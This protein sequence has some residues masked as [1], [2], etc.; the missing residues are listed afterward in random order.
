MDGRRFELGSLDCL[1]VGQGSRTVVMESQ[2]AEK[3]AR[4]YLVS[5]P[6]HASHP[7]TLMR[8]DQANR[9]ELGSAAGANQRTIF[10][11]IHEGGIQS[12]QLVLGFTRLAS[13][14]VWNTMPP[15][16]HFRRSEVYLYFDLPVDQAV[17]HLAGPP[18]ETRHLVM[19]SGQAVLSP[20]WSIH[21]GCGTSSYAFVWSMG[22]ENKRFNDMD[23]API[24]S[25][26]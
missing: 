19:R 2:E 14:S 25:L 20:P 7:T 13:G 4:F 6:A 12:C 26:A 17:I 15:H 22:G 11:Y 5:A 23:S 21:C 9:V 1:Y 3:P 10:Q 8:H 16:T 18:E 24:S